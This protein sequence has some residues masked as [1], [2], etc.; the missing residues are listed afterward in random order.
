MTAPHHAPGVHPVIGVDAGTASLR[1][2]DHLIH[3]LMDHLD[4]PPGTIA[5]THLIRTDE[6]RCV[7]ITLAL[8]DAE[9]AEA[10]WE[11]LADV[12]G[13]DAG[14]VLGG[15]ERGPAQAARGAA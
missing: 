4:L 12:L 2:A 14:A 6:R 8:P 7:A 1:Q 3:H 13:P 15:R 9:A 10:V 11:R 5:C